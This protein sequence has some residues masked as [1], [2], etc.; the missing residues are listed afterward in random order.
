MEDVEHAV[1]FHLLKKESISEML[2]SNI[3][4]LFILEQFEDFIR[5][6]GLYSWQ[7]EDSKKYR[8]IAAFFSFGFH[9]NM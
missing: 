2:P 8:S 1:S 9:S 5:L 6:F 7:S 3:K 4:L